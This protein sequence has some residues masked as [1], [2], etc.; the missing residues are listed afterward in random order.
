MVINMNKLKKF[1]LLEIFK[2]ANLL[3]LNDQDI[4][5][6]FLTKEISNIPLKYNFCLHMFHHYEL[7]ASLGSDYHPLT[8]FKVANRDLYRQ[9]NQATI[10]HCSLRIKPDYFFNSKLLDIIEKFKSPADYIHTL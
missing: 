10:I 8:F 3:Q 2:N 6:R 4:L 1:A 7:Q 9:I 5:N